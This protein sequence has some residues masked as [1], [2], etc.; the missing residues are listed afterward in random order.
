MKILRQML[1]IKAVWLTMLA[2]VGISQECIFVL[3]VLFDLAVLF[4]RDYNCQVY[5]YIC[6][7]NQICQAMNV[8]LSRIILQQLRSFISVVQKSSENALTYL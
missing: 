8:S 5:V 4:P 1:R 7:E 3:A 2:G 6:K